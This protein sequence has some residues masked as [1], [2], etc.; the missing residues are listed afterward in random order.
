MLESIHSF[1]YKKNFGQGGMPE[2]FLKKYTNLAPKVS[3]LY[4][5]YKKSSQEFK[6]V[7]KKESSLYSPYKLY[8]KGGG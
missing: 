2:S 4:S 6:R 8:V 7:H 5:S 1:L 3:S